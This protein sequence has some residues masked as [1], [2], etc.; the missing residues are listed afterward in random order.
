MQLLRSIFYGFSIISLLL[1]GTLA[2]KYEIVSC[3]KDIFVNHLILG[4]NNPLT[5]LSNK[6]QQNIMITFV[7]RDN[8]HSLISGIESM[9]IEQ[10]VNS[11]KWFSFTVLSIDQPQAIRRRQTKYKSKFYVVLLRNHYNFDK[12]L[13]VI[14]NAPT[15][16]PNAFFI[17]YIEDNTIG[18]TFIAKNI[19]MSMRAR[20]LIYGAV[21]VKQEDIYNVYQLSFETKP[22]HICA[23][24]PKLRL[25]DK[26]I[27]GE[28]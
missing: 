16:N 13:D 25:I 2:N 10:C 14:Q 18:N 4:D 21:L 11:S 28:Y 3:L 23:A 9:V 19:V 1:K 5:H 26:C 7:I 20:Y 6:Y 24:H 17:I 22:M 27:N 12:A 8:N 15:Y